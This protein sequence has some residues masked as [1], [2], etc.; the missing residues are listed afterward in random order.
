MNG[1]YIDNELRIDKLYSDNG[2]GAGILV[3]VR[4]GLKLF[5]LDDN[6]TFNQYCRFFLTNDDKSEKLYFTVVYRSPN[7][8]DEN[9]DKLVTLIGN[10]NFNDKHIILGDFNYPHI[11]WTTLASDNKSRSFVDMI[12]DKSLSQLVDFPTHIRGNILDLIL[13]NQPDSFISV[14][15]LGN[16]HNSDHVMLL[17]E[18]DFDVQPS[19]TEQMIPDW[20]NLDE[21]GFNN[22]LQGFDWQQVI[23]GSVENS[24]T[25]LKDVINNGCENFLPL[26]QRRISNKPIWFTQNIAR[27]IRI[28]QRR[29]KVYCQYKNTDNLSN[30]KESEKNCKKAVLKAKK[31]FEKKLSKKPNDKQFYSYVKS[32]TKGKSNIGPLKV[33]DTIISDDAEICETLNNYFASVFT[34]E[35]TTNVP[36]AP[37]MNYEQSISSI[38]ITQAK[39]M[40]KLESL[41]DKSS[42]GPDGFTNR[43]FK[44]FKQNLCLPLTLLFKKSVETGDVPLDWKSANVTPIFKKGGKGNPDNYR[45]ISLT[46]IPGK[47]LESIIKDQVIDHLNTN[48]LIHDTQHGFMK[49]KSCTTNLL[50]FLE[51]VTNSVDK[52][53]CFD[54]V[55]LDFCK[56]FD[57]VP[58]ERLLISLK[59]HGID[60]FLL[61]WL[62][63]WLRNRRQRVVLNGLFSTWKAVL[64]GVPQGSI[65]GPL[66]FLIFINCFDNVALLITILR[67][68]ADDAKL[69]QIIRDE[70][71]RQRLQECLNNLSEWAV[72]WG[73]KFNVKKCSVLHLGYRNPDYQYSLHPEV[74]APVEVERDVGIMISSNMKPSTHCRDIS[75]K[76][77]FVL[78]QILQCFHYRDRNVFLSLY[79]QR[80]RP[81]LEFGSPVWNPWL[82]ADK[83][84]IE[85]VQIKAVNAISGLKG[86]SY[87]E[88][89]KE[90]NL[91]SLDMRRLKA[92]LIQTYKILN[93]I[94]DVKPETWFQTVGENPVRQTRLT[95]YSLNLIK[96]R[97]RL[98]IRGN[99]FSQRVIVPWNNLPTTVKSKPTISAFKKALDKHLLNN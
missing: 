14:E 18:Y 87:E 31:N 37:E 88:K 55:Y 27:L 61:T 30:Y 19:T 4:N 38:D 42:P 32:K 47:I 26:K 6:S 8:S 16:L 57:K 91:M 70:T 97:S 71:D 86:K 75:R 56:A 67:K 33:N 89:L 48:N 99:F 60:G 80:V 11:D 43:L 36:Q 15:N 1:Y 85:K 50:E 17:A 22:Y 63:N 92:D 10:S 23:T 72:T 40:Q 73:M 28:K 13:T 24:W 53:Q 98:D 45:Q 35:D 68:F 81:I 96:T 5:K 25:K 83:D 74:L 29:Y 65:L 44:T 51:I 34:D 66:L 2:I 52:G 3:F 41:K 82:K 94:D 7:T 76:A 58:T 62:E 84:C 79:K 21:Q 9:N 90:I 46:S 78:N 69:G 12:T 93:R 54:I 20:R 64:S 39:V 59:A 49:N 77:T 95:D